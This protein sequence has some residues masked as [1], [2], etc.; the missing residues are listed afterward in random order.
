[1]S[2]MIVILL[3]TLKVIWS[4]GKPHRRKQAV[5]GRKPDG[6]N[7]ASAL[8]GRCGSTRRE[9]NSPTPYVA[10]ASKYVDV[11]IVSEFVNRYAR[12]KHQLLGS[13][14]TFKD[15]RKGP[16]FKLIAQEIAGAVRRVLHHCTRL[17]S[18]FEALNVDALVDE[19]EEGDS[20][21]NDLVLVELCK[22]G[23]RPDT[24]PS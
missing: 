7:P 22:G 15:F 17:E 19:Y 23:D 18:D 21:F 12:V 3:N 9:L 8:S 6:S 10:R 5:L 14:M 11:L 2:M 4:T 13:G 20:D 16:T 24:V 1:M